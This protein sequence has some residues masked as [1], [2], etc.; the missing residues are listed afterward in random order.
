MPEKSASYWIF[1]TTY[2]GVLIPKTLP[3]THATVTRIYL[4][5]KLNFIN[6]PVP[7]VVERDPLSTLNDRIL[8]SRARHHLRSRFA[9]HLVAYNMVII[10]II[11]FFFFFRFVVW[12]PG[13][14]HDK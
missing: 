8:Q 5:K 2:R 9:L 11:W 13:D 6:H 7:C 10:M 1:S 3:W 12:H 14:E 4:N